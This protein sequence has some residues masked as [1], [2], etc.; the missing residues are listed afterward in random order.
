[1][2]LV[3]ATVGFVTS[4]YLVALHESLAGGGPSS[5]V[6]TIG[7]G[8]DCT[9]AL[10]SPYASIWG[11][12]VAAYA[13]WFYVFVAIIASMRSFTFNRAVAEAQP[14]ILLGATIAGVLV[15]IVLGMISVFSIGV[16]CPL[17]TL[18]YAVNLGLCAVAW[19]DIARRP[20][21]LA[22]AWAALRGAN[23]RRLVPVLLCGGPILASLLALPIA[24][25]LADPTSEFC[26]A[27]R[28]ARGTDGLSLTAYVDFQC[29]S[30]QD[31]EKQLHRA[32]SKSPFE[33]VLKPYPLEKDCNP[34][35]SRTLFPGACLQAR[36]A[37]CAR[38]DG[39]LDDLALQLFES[40]A[41]DEPALI[42]I[43]GALGID[44]A[45]F[46]E[47]L[48]ARS[49]VDELA[50]EIRTAHERGV[51]V[52]PTLFINDVRHVGMLSPRDLQCLEGAGR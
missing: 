6:C 18:L 3:L 19:I 44:Q 21:G 33:L 8:I 28:D 25:S 45:T 41:S 39:R 46:S 40:G 52:T 37:I 50:A 42:A 47:C 9:P 29:A 13:A 26:Q 36:G 17:C 27:I 38:R 48:S 14:A 5:A 34:W 1:M 15:S 35:P 51:R 12:P 11:V 2:I 7:T 43:A 31:L 49:T 4:L 23:A 30:C 16:L 20:G 22:T 24:Y 32:H 10:R